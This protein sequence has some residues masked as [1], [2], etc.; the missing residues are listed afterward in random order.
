MSPK[1]G[2]RES[3]IHG[4][5]L[6]AKDN[7]QKGEKTV[8]WGGV[9]VNEQGAE[10]CK[11]Q[12]K[13]VMQWDNNLYSCEDPGDEKGYFINYSCDPNMWMFDAYTLIARRD[14]KKGGELTVDYVFWEADESYI[15]KWK[16]NCGSSLCRGRVTGKD[17]RSPILQK[18]YKNHFSPLINKRIKALSKNPTT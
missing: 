14:V 2:I 17:W 10:G 7:I 13:L 12:G 4:R 9:Y 18:R 16:Y 6:F 1:V 8:V 3:K 11:K 5:G 15:S